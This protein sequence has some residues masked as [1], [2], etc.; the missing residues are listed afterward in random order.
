MRGVPDREERLAGL[1]V[2]GSTIVFGPVIWAS[3]RW[4]TTAARD[5]ANAWGARGLHPVSIP[6]PALPLFLLARVVPA[7]RFSELVRA[8][9]PLLPQAFFVLFRAPPLPAFEVA[10]AV[11]LRHR[12]LLSVYGIC[13]TLSFNYITL[14]VRAVPSGS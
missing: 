12:V 8:T 10:L 14:R 6:G 13:T 11:A 5:P 7:P 1:F 9:L 4:G 3:Q 2:V